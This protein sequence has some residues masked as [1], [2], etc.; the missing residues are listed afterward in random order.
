[1]QNQNMNS[2]NTVQGGFVAPPPLPDYQPPPPPPPVQTMQLPEIP[3]QPEIH[4]QTHNLQQPPPKVQIASEQQSDSSLKMNEPQT[5]HTNQMQASTSVLSQDNNFNFEQS[6]SQNYQDGFRRNNRNSRWGNNNNGGSNSGNNNRNNRM[7]GGNTNFNNQNTTSH[8]EH[9]LNDHDNEETSREEKSQEEIA[10]D[11]QFQK[12]EDQLAE[13]KRNNANHP[14]RNQYNDFVMKMEGC[15]KQL[16]QRR[17]SFRQKRLDRNRNAQ[18]SRNSQNNPSPQDM[19][20][21]EISMEV[22]DQESVSQANAVANSFETKDSTV[23]SSLFSSE[24]CDSNAAI[25]GLD[26]V[27]GNETPS[28]SSAPLQSCA[29]SQCNAPPKCETTNSDSASN[30]VARVTNILG[31][32]E[33]QSLLSNIQKQQLGTATSQSNIQA[34]DFNENDAQRG[35]A[36]VFNR[37]DNL[38][39]FDKQQNTEEPQ[40]NPFRQNIRSDIDMSTQNASQQEM[41]PKRGRYDSEN[42]VN[43]NSQFDRFNRERNDP[44]TQVSLAIYLLLV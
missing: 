18:S 22:T 40:R 10:F 8:D 12:W 4:A 36:N 38:G 13:W 33:I 20:K 21:N 2:Q 43:H 39:H 28:Q 37:P 25:P 11:I 29:P 9:A 3:V 30:I 16:M 6:H 24:R 1:M 27:S 14:D 5:T 44:F 23:A 19:N 15:R 41:N 32:P 35:G 7:F 42:T 26:L 34:R 31:N 17:E